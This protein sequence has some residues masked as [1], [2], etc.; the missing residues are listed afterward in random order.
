MS[1]DPLD[2]WL[3]R[4][5]KE[6]PARDLTVRI[7]AVVA[8]RRRART[9]WRH[10]GATALV[11]ALAGVMLVLVSWPHVV[12]SLTP[13]VNSFE[14]NDLAPAFNALLTTPGETLIA[15]LDAGLAWQAAQ[16]EGLGV[17]FMLGVALLAVAAFGGLAQMVR[18]RARGGYSP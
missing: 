3:A 5:P 15:W 14:T 9:M 2:Q 12:A 18:P 13:A 1:S 8:Q 6:P 7:V 11:C 10:L 16:A 17:A 4:L